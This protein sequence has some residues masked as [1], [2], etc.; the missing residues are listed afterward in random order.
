MVKI[1]ALMHAYKNLIALALTCVNKLVSFEYLKEQLQLFIVQAH[2]LFY[3][4]HFVCYLILPGWIV[5]YI[6]DRT[7]NFVI[8]G[9]S[10]GIE[11]AN[12]R[13]F[14]MSYRKKLKC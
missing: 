2:F 10:S 11:N 3:L 7:Q 5:H 6:P 14:A 4:A 8:E 9:Y 12:A 13:A 1:V